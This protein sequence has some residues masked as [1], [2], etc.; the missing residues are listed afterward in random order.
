MRR[1]KG[2]MEAFRIEAFSRSM[3][4]RFATVVQLGGV[5]KERREGR[6]GGKEGRGGKGGKGGREKDLVWR[7]RRPP[8]V[9]ISSPTRPPSLPASAPNPKARKPH[10]QP[11]S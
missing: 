5:S 9:N 11:H 2:R 3:K 4:P 8:P 1:A 7:A 6:K 10:S